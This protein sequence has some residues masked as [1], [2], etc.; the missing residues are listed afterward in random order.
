MY[1]FFTTLN[2]ARQ[3]AGN[4][5]SSFYTSQVR[6][7]PAEIKPR[8]TWD[9]MNISTLSANTLLISKPPLISLLTN[10]GSSSSTG[11]QLAV[12]ASSSNWTAKTGIVDIL[13][14]TAYTTDSSGNLQITMQQDGTPR[15]L[16]ASAQ[17]GS[18]CSN[19]SPSAPTT[20]SPASTTK[21]KSAASR[22]GVGWLTAVPALLGFLLM[23][24]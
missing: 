21:G 1:K 11:S 4:A 12:P 18:L 17:K 9:Q 20:S 19:V 15:V 2:A 5:S 16:I 23:V 22:T 10:Q 6:F 7:N 3:A 24:V 13:T 14:C 8:L